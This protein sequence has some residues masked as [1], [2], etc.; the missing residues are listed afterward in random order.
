MAVDLG[1][2]KKGHFYEEKLQSIEENRYLI[3]RIIRTRKI[4]QGSQEL[5][6]N[7]TGWPTKFKSRVNEED[8]DYIGKS[9]EDESE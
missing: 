1:D 7:W 6:G 5:L 2:N 9:K 3:E 4:K 8:C